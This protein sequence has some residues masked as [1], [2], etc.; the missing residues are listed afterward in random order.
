MISSCK[1]SLS[2]QKEHKHTFFRR[3]FYFLVKR[4]V[5]RS[6]GVVIILSRVIL[7]PE[8]VSC[9]KV[10]KFHNI[11]VVDIVEVILQKFAV[12]FIT[13]ASK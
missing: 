1:K 12:K 10:S 8:F 2:Q 7:I 5:L 11:F 4:R 6:V 9:C 13:D 3:S